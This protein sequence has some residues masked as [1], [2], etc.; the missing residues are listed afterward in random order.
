MLIANVADRI[1]AGD[2]VNKRQ[3]DAGDATTL[4]AAG[5]YVDA[6]ETA[7]RGD[8]AVGDAATLQA[9]RSYARSAAD[10][11]LQSAN[12][13]T[14]SQVP[15]LNDR[16]ERLAE[17]VDERLRGYDRRL[18]RIGAM[19]GAMSAAALNTAGLTGRN[20]IGLGVGTQGGENAL[21]MGY[22][23]VIGERVSVSLSAGF[24]GDDRSVAAGTGFSW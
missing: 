9:A 1:A 4:A 2:A 20:R 24:S 6:R 22:Q 23:R 16:F 7:V 17:G 8:M 5:D 19:G 11:A 14:D 10:G 12:A 13:Y 18:D 15:V 3:L 21:A